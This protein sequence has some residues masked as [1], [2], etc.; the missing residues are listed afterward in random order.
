MPKSL[1]TKSI[2]RNSDKDKKFE[3]ETQSLAEQEPV[4]PERK[5]Q[6]LRIQEGQFKLQQELEKT[7]VLERLEDMKIK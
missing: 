3:V 4:K 2:S 7:E 6:K 5:L 1:Q